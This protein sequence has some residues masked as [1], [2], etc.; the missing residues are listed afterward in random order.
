MLDR[1]ITHLIN[2]VGEEYDGGY[3]YYGPNSSPYP[4]TSSIKWQKWLSNPPKGLNS[5][6][7]PERAISPLQ[8]YPW[9]L[10]SPS[11]PYIV[12]FNS[13]GTYA[14]HLLRFSL[15]G[16]PHSTDL[17]V[18]LDGND[19]GWEPRLDVGMDRWHYDIMQN[20]PL[21][22]GSHNFSFV[23]GNTAVVGKAQLCS[24]EIIEY[25]DDFESV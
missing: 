5:T 25:G 8:A 23:L 19:V 12:S 17:S 9:T 11:E 1:R 2:I 10:L 7:S 22:P 24:L 6:I 15:S 14:S 16:L 18:L 13:S 21:A 4:L 20:Y 3:A